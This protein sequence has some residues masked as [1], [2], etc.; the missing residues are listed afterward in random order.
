MHFNIIPLSKVFD[1]LYFIQ[2][3]LV[4]LVM[5][6]TNMYGLSHFNPLNVFQ[7]NTIWQEVPIMKSFVNFCQDSYC[8]VS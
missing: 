8:S 6:R 2:A 7:K 1:V 5:Q 3:Y 4:T